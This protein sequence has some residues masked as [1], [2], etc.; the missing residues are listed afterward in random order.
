[1]RAK[2]LAKSSK[3]LSAWVGILLGNIVRISLRVVLNATRKRGSV[4]RP[5]A[6]RYQHCNMPAVFGQGR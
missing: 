6:L 2:T 1:M 4:L 5:P 3:R